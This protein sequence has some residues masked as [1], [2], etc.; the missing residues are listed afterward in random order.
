MNPT[1][2]SYLKLAATKMKKTNMAKMLGMFSLAL[3]AGCAPIYALVLPGAALADGEELVAEGRISAAAISEPSALEKSRRYADTFWT[4]NDSGDRSRIFAISSSGAIIG[5]PGL[6]N[7]QGIEVEDAKNKDWESLAVDDSGHLYIVDCGN[8][9]SKRK[10]LAIYIVD[11]PDPRTVTNVVLQRKI[12]FSYPDQHEYPALQANFDAE[13]VFWTGGS[14]Y[15]LT[16]HRDDT[17]T[18]LYRFGDLTSGQETVPT[19]LETFEVG[20]MVTGADASD[21]GRQLAVLTYG[22]VWL[23]TIPGPD[24]ALLSGP[25]YRRPIMAK[26]VEGICFDGESLLLVNEQGEIFRLNTDRRDPAWQLQGID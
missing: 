25:V 26:Q 23:F 16:K 21:D 22:H 4:I 2:I 17:M 20:G 13:A 1:E 18:K 14:L 11:E 12:T 24:G 6:T 10:K 8:N 7:N 15:L 9:D 3:I 5:P 19:L